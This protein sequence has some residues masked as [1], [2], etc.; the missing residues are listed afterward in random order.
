MRNS[1]FLK[2]VICFGYF[3]TLTTASKADLTGMGTILRLTGKSTVD[4]WYFDVNTGGQISFDVK[5]WEREPQ[6][7][8][9]DVDVNNDGE[10]AYLNTMIFLFAD[11]G[12]LDVSDYLYKNDNSSATFGDGSISNKDSYLSKTLTSGS[13]ILAIGATGL[14]AAQAINGFRTSSYYPRGPNFASSS[15]G[16]YQILFRGDLSIS[17]TPPGALLTP[18]PQTVLLFLAGFCMIVLMRGGAP[19]RRASHFLTIKGRL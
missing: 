18:E 7:P 13:Y 5:S 1:T 9:N 14:D 6:A 15:H 3:F 16:D 8:L 4:H 11:D 17:Q 12:H 2:T 19:A 10:I